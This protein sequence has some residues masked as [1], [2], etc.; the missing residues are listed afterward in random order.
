MAPL[1]FASP[2]SSRYGSRPWGGYMP[3][4]SGVNYLSVSLPGALFAV[5]SG[6][7]VRI[8]SEAPFTDI[9]EQSSDNNPADKPDWFLCPVHVSRH[10]LPRCGCWPSPAPPSPYFLKQLVRRHTSCLSFII[11]LQF[12]I[13]ILSI[14]LSSPSLSSLFQPKLPSHYMPFLKKKQKK[15]TD[16]TQVTTPNPPRHRNRLFLP[17]SPPSSTDGPLGSLAKHR[18]L[19]DGARPDTRRGRLPRRGAEHLPRRAGEAACRAG[20]RRGRGRRGGD[21]C[22]RAALGGRFEARV[23][24]RR[25]G[26]AVLL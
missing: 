4:Q 16:T 18:H 24:C 1:L 15:L 13:P 10:H 19:S 26:G 21:W 3:Q 5:V 22:G 23:S 8:F 20:S 2:I 7:M 14:S 25:L 11:P 9:C 12:L 17:D 6:V